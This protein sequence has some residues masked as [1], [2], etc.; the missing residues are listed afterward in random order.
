MWAKAT[1][2]E[3]FAVL[4]GNPAVDAQVQ[5]DVQLV[6]AE[7][8]ASPWGALAMNPLDVDGVQLDVYGNP[9]TYNV[10]RRHPGDLANWLMEADRIPAEAVIHWFRADQAELDQARKEWQ[11]AIGKAR[12]EKGDDGRRRGCQLLTVREVGALL[13]VSSRT[14]WRLS[15]TGA[16]RGPLDLGTRTKRW[17][18]VDVEAFL[19]DVEQGGNA[20]I[21]S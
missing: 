6:E 16:L 3:T 1:D 18:L 4:T 10:L 5:L 13:A 20:G 2:G 12:T 11:D 21:P 9:Q 8:V 15:A 17:R 14:V 7:R 19:A